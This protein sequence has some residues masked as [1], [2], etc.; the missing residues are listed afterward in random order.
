VVE[1]LYDPRGTLA[2]LFAAM[3]PGGRLHLATPNANA[4]SYR[5]FGRFWFALEC[6]RHVMIFHPEALRRLLLEAGFGTV[7]LVFESKPADTR[8]SL[9][10]LASAFGLIRSSPWRWPQESAFDAVWVPASWLSQKFVSSGRFH[11]FARKPCA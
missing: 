8:R 6:P 1:H 10:Y 9:S 11:L 5:L 7:D 4:W 3:R 2:R